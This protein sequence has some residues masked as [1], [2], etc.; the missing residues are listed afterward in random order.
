MSLAVK[1]I[2]RREII[3]ILQEEIEFYV[4]E[5]DTGET[6]TSETVFF[7]KT[8][9][10]RSFE[11]TRQ[12]ADF[13]CL[14]VEGSSGTEISVP[15]GE[16]SRDIWTHKFLVQILDKDMWDNENRQATWDKW[17]EQ[18][19]SYF[20]FHQ[21]DGLLYESQGCSV[22]CSAIPTDDIDEKLWVTHGMFVMGVIISV[23][24][25]QLRG[26]I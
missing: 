10:S 6:I 23:D 20:H 7:Q 15:L 4:T 14:L 11:S 9:K 13:P 17:Q 18:I 22:N 26:L 8:T 12:L 3:R 16:N 5:G 19:A 24:V 21:F 2:L 25:V 1:T